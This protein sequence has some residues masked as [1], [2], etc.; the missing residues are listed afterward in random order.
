MLPNRRDKQLFGLPTF[1]LFPVFG[2]SFKYKVLNEGPLP[3][4]FSLSVKLPDFSL[5]AWSLV[6]EALSP[7]SLLGFSRLGLNCS[8]GNGTKVL[9]VG[10]LLL[11]IPLEKLFLPC[12]AS[13]WI[14]VGGSLLM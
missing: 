14:V 7:T 3:G 11:D 13:V 6:L 2:V 12:K 4:R 1:I 9:V 10:G 5:F 8:T